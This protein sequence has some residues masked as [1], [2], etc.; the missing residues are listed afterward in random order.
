MQVKYSVQI[1][2]N[3][4]RTHPRLIPWIGSSDSFAWDRSRWAEVALQVAPL[5]GAV[6]AEMLGAQLGGEAPEAIFA[7]HLGWEARHD[8]MRRAS[9]AKQCP[10]LVESERV[11]VTR[12]GRIY[13][14][15]NKI[16]NG[17]WTRRMGVCRHGLTAMTEQVE[18]LNKI[19]TDSS[20]FY[21]LLGLHINF[22]Y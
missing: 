20:I 8:Q 22:W 21:Y 18:I 14:T 11:R 6:E 10:D 7:A 17:A 19:H 3:Q 2:A 15:M 9:A 16:W 12:F 4:R 5:I 1:E 13:S